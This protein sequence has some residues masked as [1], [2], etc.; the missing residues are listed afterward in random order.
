MV[1]RKPNDPPSGVVNM[2][3]ALFRA[4]QTEDRHPML[5]GHVTNPFYHKS[6]GGLGRVD[7]DKLKRPEVP[8]AI[9]TYCREAIRWQRKHKRGQ[10]WLQILVKQAEGA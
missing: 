7:I 4:S 8:E 6:L 10:P 3:N 1:S 5:D 9:K 2:N